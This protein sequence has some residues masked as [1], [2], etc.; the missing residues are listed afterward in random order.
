MTKYGNEIIRQTVRKNVDCR[1]DDECKILKTFVIIQLYLDG[2]H[3]MQFKRKQIANFVVTT[4]PIVFTQISFIQYGIYLF[5]SRVY[6]RAIFRITTNL[7]SYLIN[8]ETP[9]ALA[10][11]FDYSNE[12]LIKNRSSLPLILS[13]SFYFASAAWNIMSAIEAAEKTLSIEAP[14]VIVHVKNIDLNIKSCKFLNTNL[15]LRNKSEKTIG[16]K[17]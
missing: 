1:K 6:E 14:L 11:F 9:V 4:I 12:K 13:L 15:E 8:Y 5:F 7:R 2:V 16:L 17:K 10:H 3:D